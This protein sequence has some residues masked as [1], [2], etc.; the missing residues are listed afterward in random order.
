[1]ELRYTLNLGRYRIN[2]SSAF[3]T[4]QRVSFGAKLDSDS[5]RMEKP[6]HATKLGVFKAPGKTFF[7]LQ[8]QEQMLFQSV[9]RH[10]HEIAPT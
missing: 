7:K 2:F 9:L 1:M 5:E 10:T 6:D 8:E 4:I 3:N